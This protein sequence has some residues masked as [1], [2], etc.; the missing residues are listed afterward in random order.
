MRLFR[1]PDIR[2]WLLTGAVALCTLGGGALATRVEWAH[3]GSSLEERKMPMKFSW[4]ACQ[5]D[6]PGWVSA[7]GIVTAET[8]GGVR[9]VCAQSQARGGYLGAGLQRRVGQRLHRARTAHSRPRHADNGRNQR[10]DPQRAGRPGTGHAGSLLRIDVRLSAA[11]G[12]HAL[13]AFNRACA[14]ASDLDGRPRRRR[15]G[16]EL[17]GAGSDDRRARYRTACQIYVRHGRGG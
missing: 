7:V 4:V 15:Q 6:C 17:H 3:A 13:R 5:P 11:R 14:G 16:I 9:R 12:Q 10:S 8:P 1:S 2:R